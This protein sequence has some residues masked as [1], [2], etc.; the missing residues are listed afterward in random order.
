MT[1][2][3]MNLRRDNAWIMDAIKDDKVT[4]KKERSLI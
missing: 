1:Y 4:N 2:Q 3:M